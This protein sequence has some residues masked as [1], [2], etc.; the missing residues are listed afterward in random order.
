MND[1]IDIES[2]VVTD[3]TITASVVIDVPPKPRQRQPFEKDGDFNFQAPPT[4]CKCGHRLV[5]MQGIDYTVP[6]TYHIVM[7]C[8]RCQGK[9]KK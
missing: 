3:N 4:T 7:A 2:E 5:F 8:P 1:V 6:K 9:Q